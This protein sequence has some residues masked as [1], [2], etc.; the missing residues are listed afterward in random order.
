[1]DLAG[2]SPVWPARVLR[3]VAAQ[4]AAFPAMVVEDD[5]GPLAIIGMMPGEIDEIW[6]AARPGIAGTPRAVRLMLYLAR[7]A[8]EWEPQRAL[9]VQAGTRAGAGLAR[10]CGFQPVEHP[11]ASGVHVR[12]QL[13]PPP[14]A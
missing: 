11:H 9:G 12:P 4:I 13:T 7:R 2:L 6:F 1:M 3:R 5:A 14:P 8:R 10:L